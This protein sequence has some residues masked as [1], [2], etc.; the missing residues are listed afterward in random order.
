MGR[1]SSALLALIAMLAA[2]CGGQPATPSPTAAPATSA[3][4]ASAAPTV[5]TGE[6]YKIG[7][8]F[9]ITGA[10]S[11]L[12]IPER[13]TV[14]MLEAQVNAA[15]GIKGPDGKLHKVQ[16]IIYDNQSQESQTVL[17]A[18]RLIEEDKVPVVIG[19]SQSGTT[20]AIVDTMQKAQVPLISAAASAAIVEP[21]AD[22]KWVFKTPQ[23][24]KLIMTF[25]LQWLKSKSIT[26]VAWLSVN[27]A[28]GDGGRAQ[29][30][31]LSGA[32]GVTAVA[33][34]RF[35]AT[36][37]D[38]TAQLTKIKGSGAQALI[39]WAVPPGA[40]VATKN[41][42]DLGITM[43]IFQSHGIGT[44]AFIDLAGPAANGVVFP[45]G[46]LLVASRLPDSDPQK[47]VLTDYTAAYQKAYGK[48]PTTFG[49]HA[50]DA[51]WIAEK[52]L[53]KAGP[54]R[55]AIRDQI[56]QV[57]DFVG[58]TGVFNFSAQDHNGLDKRAVT[59]VTVAGGKWAPAQ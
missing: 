59:A 17:V 4:A 40:S 42:A 13:D 39:V 32:A 47:K 25:L 43:P 27:N 34:E 56:E 48:A 8:I 37:T 2:A 57:R 20:L 36:D 6:T 26:K 41:A 18:K 50:W 22:H 45:A 7:A 9:D 14:K 52:A 15:G 29:F 53:E 58:I 16:V 3:A 44:P 38:M 33:N 24:D 23:S 30:D 5:A 31:A 54:D 49:G 35:G 51:F 11:A 55:A 46:K 28:F 21:V 12:G 10:G 19:P 1:R